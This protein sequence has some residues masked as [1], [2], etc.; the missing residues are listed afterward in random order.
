[1]VAVSSSRSLAVAGGDV[2]G[3]LVVEG[4][5]LVVKLVERF[6]VLEERVLV[7]EEVVGDPVDLALHLL[8]ARGELGDRSGAAR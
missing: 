5:R 2:E 3:E 4:Q 1:M 7:L 6:D 8:E